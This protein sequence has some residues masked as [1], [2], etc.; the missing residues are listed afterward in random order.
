MNITVIGR[1]APPSRAALPSLIRRLTRSAGIYFLNAASPS[2]ISAMA[3][4]RFSIS[5]NR[6]ECLS[7]FSR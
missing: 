2:A 7:T 5:A 4:D 3:P 6:E 1:I